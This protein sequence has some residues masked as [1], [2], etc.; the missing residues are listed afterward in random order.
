[1]NH[2]IPTIFSLKIT[3][4]RYFSAKISQNSK[5]N[6]GKYHKI[7]KTKVVLFPFQHIKISIKQLLC[8]N[9][10]TH[11]LAAHVAFDQGEKVG[12]ELVLD[13]LFF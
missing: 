10:S 4:F 8:P 7:P 1:M 6:K 13:N 5:P 3:K 12:N 11:P 9:V 2:R